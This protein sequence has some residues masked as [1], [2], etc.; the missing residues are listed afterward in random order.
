[1]EISTTLANVNPLDS[2]SASSD[3]VRAALRELSNFYMSLDNVSL[4]LLLSQNLQRFSDP[5]TPGFITSDFLM[6]IVKG[7]GGNKFTQADQALALEILSR[8]EFLSTIDLD[9]NNQRDGKIDLNDIH[10][11]I[12]SL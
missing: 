1:M 2:S 4:A 6:V 10:R 12:D 11:Y 7:Q 3:N 5:E 8:N 9:S